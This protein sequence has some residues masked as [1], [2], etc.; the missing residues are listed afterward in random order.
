MV[1]V[2]VHID[3]VE[4]IVSNNLE[5]FLD[6]IRENTYD[7][8]SFTNKV[9]VYN[10]NKVEVYN[11]EAFIKTQ[12][13]DVKYLKIA[14]IWSEN[15]YSTRS[16]VGAIMV[17]DKTIISDGFNGM[18]KDFPNSC[19]DRNGVT[20]IEVLHAE[21]NCITK[22]AKSNNSSRGATLYCTMSPCI[23]CAKMI[24]QCEISRVVF[25]NLYRTTE[26]L[27][28]L[29]DYGQCSLVFYKI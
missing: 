8:V 20:N 19:E 21:A 7:C 24:V 3:I 13:Y 28:L 10:S 27:K 9:E 17:K 14:Q 1:I 22:V 6:K 15:S 25:S 16:K 4:N 23:E 5:L 2:L 11:S 29:M 12:L 18:P 26:G